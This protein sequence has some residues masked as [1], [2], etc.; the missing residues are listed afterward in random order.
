MEKDKDQAISG[1]VMIELE[2]EELENREAPQI[3]FPSG[4]SSGYPD[5]SVRF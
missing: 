1:T 4:P 2:I 3:A 5:G